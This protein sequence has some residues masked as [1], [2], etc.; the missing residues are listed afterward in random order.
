MES[1][2]NIEYNKLFKAISKLYGVIEID[3]LHSLLKRFYRNIKKDNILNE[4]IELSSSN[5]GEY[6]LLSENEY[7]YLVN[8]KL[9]KEIALS[10]VNNRE[11]EISFYVPRNLEE[12]LSYEDDLFMTKKEKEAYDELKDFMM[13]FYEVKNE[14]NKEKEIEEA[15]VEIHYDFRLNKIDYEFKQKSNQKRFSFNE[16]DLEDFKMIFNKVLFLTRLYVNKGHS[17]IELAMLY[18]KEPFKQKVNKKIKKYYFDKEI[19]SNESEEYF[20]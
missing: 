17:E 2:K 3:E 8:A 12:L 15:L 9:N 6:Y 1:I 11:N 10:I 14:N 5:K 13:K 7:T 20:A 18:G 19:Y 4:L 16:E